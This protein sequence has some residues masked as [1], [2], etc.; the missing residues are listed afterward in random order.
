MNQSSIELKLPDQELKEIKTRLYLVIYPVISAREKHTNNA[1]A[2]TV[3]LVDSIVQDMEQFI[4]QNE[5]EPL[6]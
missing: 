6:N 2:Q 1:H 4:D 5:P 3:K